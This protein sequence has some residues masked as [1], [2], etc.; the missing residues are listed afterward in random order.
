MDRLE[1]LQR[2]LRKEDYEKAEEAD[3]ILSES[4]TEYHNAIKAKIYDKNAPLRRIKNKCTFTKEVIS[5]C[6]YNLYESALVIDDVDKYSKSLRAVMKEQLMSIMENAETNNDLNLLFENASPYVKGMMI[7]A[8]EA[9]SKKSDEDIK[10]FENKV[11]LSKDD[12][13]LI[14]K[15][16]TDEGKDVYASNLQDRVID[17]YKA[18]EKLGEEQKEKV[19]TVVDELSKLTSNKPNN[20]DKTSSKVIEESVNLFN[21]TP[22][23]IFNAIFVNK[24]KSFM[25]ET[26]SSNLEENSEKILA[27]TIATYTLLE[28]IHALGFKTYSEDEKNQLRLD[29]FIS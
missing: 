18:E 22:K 12:L 23:T 15:F 26:A 11:L 5:E 28:T 10:E 3:R 17:V 27:E 4:A 25:N 1:E 9:Y 14:N 21:N 16:E 6:M 19:Q 24:S 20:E 13:E 2:L 29:F 8:E 7:L